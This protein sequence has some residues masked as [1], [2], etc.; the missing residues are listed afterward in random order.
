MSVVIRSIIIL[1]KA[2][3]YSLRQ[4]LMAPGLSSAMLLDLRL[5]SSLASVLGGRNT[6]SAE[7]TQ[8]RGTDFPASGV[9]P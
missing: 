9:V 3:W 5:C 8:P 2:A 7:G 1:L 4:E 6:R